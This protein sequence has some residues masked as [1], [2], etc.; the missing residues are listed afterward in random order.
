MSEITFDE[1]M[2]NIETLVVKIFND[3]RKLRT[4]DELD[5]VVEQVF[6]ELNDLENRIAALRNNLEMVKK[7]IPTAN[8]N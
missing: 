1:R 2:T 5:A 6:D 3:F 8:G 4:E 7:I